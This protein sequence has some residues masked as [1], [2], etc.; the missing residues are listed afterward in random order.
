MKI[1]THSLTKRLTCSH[2]LPYLLF[3]ISTHSLTKRLTFF[4][5]SNNF[6]FMYFNSQSHEETDY[7]ST[8]SYD[9][10]VYISTHSL[11]K[12][13]TGVRDE[14]YYLVVISTHSLTKRL[15]LCQ[16]FHCHLHHI[17]THSLTKRLTAIYN[18]LNIK[19]AK[20]FIIFSQSPSFSFLKSFLFLFPSQNYIHILWC[21]SPKNFCELHIRIQNIRVSSLTSNPGLAP[22]CSTLFLYLSPK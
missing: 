11:T 20:F 18:N 19:I 3:D 9:V 22:I 2:D 7:S 8:L 1:S 13:L 10:L 4:S 12:R 6:S 15:T 14:H 21:E 16:Q 5:L 17:S